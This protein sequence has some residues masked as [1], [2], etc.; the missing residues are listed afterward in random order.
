[1][2]DPTPPA[3]KTNRETVL[4]LIVLGV[5][6]VGLGA[7][8]FSRQASAQA[9]E[10]ALLQARSDAETR[11]AD[12]HA[13]QPIQKIPGDLLRVN[14]DAEAGTPYLFEMKNFAQ[15]ATYELDFGDGTGR[16]PLINGKLHH[17]YRRH[18]E[19]TVRLYARYQGQEALI[20]SIPKEVGRPLEVPIIVPGFD[21]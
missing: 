12:P 15:G 21:D 18:G 2:P 16:Q 4:L 20:D 11:A 14:T 7:L 9:A 1:M 17:T 3:R 19:Y 8:Y 5:G 10:R 13:A 6:L